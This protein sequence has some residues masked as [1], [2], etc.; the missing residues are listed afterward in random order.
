MRNPQTLAEELYT[1]FPNDR[2]CAIKDFACCA[3]VLLWCLRIEPDDTTAIMTV[4]DLIDEGAIERDCTVLW[5]DA[6]R[7]LTG[8]DL[9]SV[10]FAGISS[11][12]NV[13]DRTPVRYDY[14]GR[15]H[16]VGVENGAVA[17]NPLRSSVCVEKGRPVTMRRLIF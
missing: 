16:W 13:R 1:H 6:V 2:L 12:R 5:K 4:S 7:R 10:E 17:F 9:R 11:I 14:N 3:F 8:R 15:Q